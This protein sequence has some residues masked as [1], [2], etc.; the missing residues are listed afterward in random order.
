MGDYFSDFIHRLTEFQISQ[1]RSDDLSPQERLEV[2]LAWSRRALFPPC[3]E[4]HPKV[5]RFRVSLG[6]IRLS[7]EVETNLG[8]VCG[9]SIRKC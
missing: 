4:R 6:E 2:G 3:G 9:I 5:S 8:E 1:Y 7:V